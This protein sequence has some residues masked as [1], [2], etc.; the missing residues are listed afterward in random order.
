MS[1][2]QSRVDLCLRS[3]SPATAGPRQRAVLERVEALAEDRLVDDVEVCWW[4]GRAGI[5]DT[6]GSDGDSLPRPVTDLLV[7]ADAMDIDLRP[8]HATRVHGTGTDGDEPPVPPI[9]LVVREGGTIVGVY[10]L[11]HDGTR[12]TVDDC[13]AALAGGERA[14]NLPPL[15]TD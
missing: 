14:A 15:L 1:V 8:S 12:H 13:L 11:H 9:A 10:P 2:G 5:A 6:G 3:P 7:L 4:G